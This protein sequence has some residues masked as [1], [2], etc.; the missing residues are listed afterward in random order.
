MG[1]RNFSSLC[2]PWRMSFVIIFSL[3]LFVPSL[4]ILIYGLSKWQQIT[5]PNR[6]VVVDPEPAAGLSLTGALMSVKPDE[7]KIYIEWRVGG[8]G[9]CSRPKVN[10]SSLCPLYDTMP[11]FN[12]SDVIDH[13]H[14]IWFDGQLVFNSSAVVDPSS[15][16]ILPCGD[17]TTGGRQF[18]FGHTLDVGLDYHTQRT[19]RNS[20]P[21]EV[22]TTSSRICAFDSE[23]KSKPPIFSAAVLVSRVD[24]FLVRSQFSQIKSK[25]DPWGSVLTLT[26]ERDSFA[27]FFAIS[28]WATGWILTVLAV[29]YAVL[30]PLWAYATPGVPEPTAIDFTRSTVANGIPIE[31]ARYEGLLRYFAPRR[32]SPKTSEALWVTGTIGGILIVIR[33]QYPGS[34]PL[35]TYLDYFGFYPSFFLTA[36][37]LLLGIAVSSRI[38][39]TCLA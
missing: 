28:L 8:V 39:D 15:G 35:A 36:M 9:N 12:G 38:V 13:R 16:K 29:I 22:W 4:A 1:M 33:S 17:Y 30:S 20:Y 11:G 23:G 27:R 26:L 6:Y 37:T 19:L 3:I 10:S 32:E 25:T 7:G 5:N 14:N 18:F 34:P 24:G 2:T 31:D 21:Y